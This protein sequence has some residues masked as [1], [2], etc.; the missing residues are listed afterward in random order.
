MF[1]AGAE[2]VTMESSSHNSDHSE[3]GREQ[4]RCDLLLA[5]GLLACAGSDCLQCDTDTHGHLQDMACNLCD[6]AHTF[7]R[8]ERGYW[9]RGDNK[10]DWKNVTASLITICGL[11][12]FRD[13]TKPRVHMALTLRRVFNHISNTEYLDLER[14]SLG[15]WLLGSMNRSLRE[16][17]I[18]AV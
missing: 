18:C 6:A 16:L 12:E 11:Q 2:D 8:N 4:K 10:G 17:R 14:S 13:S 15:Q 1:E 9:D 7:Q 3:R 5:L